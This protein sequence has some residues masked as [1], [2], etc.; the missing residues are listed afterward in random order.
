MTLN[1][2]HRQT[3]PVGRRRI[4]AIEQVDKS[5]LFR[6]RSPFAIEQ[7]VSVERAGNLLIFRGIRQQ[8]P[9]QLPDGKFVESQIRIQSPHNPVAPDPLPCIAILLKPIAVRIT[10]GIQPGQS[11]SFTVLGARHQT[12]DNRFIRFVA[13][14][15]QKRVYFL[16]RGR[17]SGQV[18]RQ[19]LYQR[20][21]ISL[22][23]RR[24]PFLLKPGQDK[25]IDRSTDPCGLSNRW[26]R[27]ANRSDKGPVILID[28][29][30]RDPPFEQFLLLGRESPIRFRRRH[31]R[32]RIFRQY[33][34]D[35]RTGTGIVRNNR[36]RLHRR[37]AKIQPQIRLSL[38]VVLP[39]TIKTVLGKNRT[40]VPIE[41][42][43]RIRL[44]FS[45][46]RDDRKHKTNENSQRSMCNHSDEH[47]SS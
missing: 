30:F 14:I 35:Q 36:T 41:I 45:S 8:V 22:G 11:H 18:D 20:R 2:G 29:S 31:H 24:N 12:I 39:M 15:I 27:R 33:S 13:G 34:L 42:E 23:R 4:H 7:M 21:S 40:N 44:Q 43:L 47:H 3:Q 25:S 17:Q 38:I 19:T 32:F 46:T 5:L 6:D 10:G 26:F 9:R 37:I 16:G 1:T 28:R